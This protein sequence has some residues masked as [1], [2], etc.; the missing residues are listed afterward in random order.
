MT[1]VVVLLYM[2]VIALTIFSAILHALSMSNI[3]DGVKYLAKIK[4]NYNYW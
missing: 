1:L 4:E 2:I 3:L